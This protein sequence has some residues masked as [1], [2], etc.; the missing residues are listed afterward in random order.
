MAAGTTI[1]IVTGRSQRFD[2]TLDGVLVLVLGLDTFFRFFDVGG[3]V[4]C[5]TAFAAATLPVEE[6]GVQPLV[7]DCPV[8]WMSGRAAQAGAGIAP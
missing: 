1:G 8:A 7:K 2:M 5:T 4:A 3:I 6:V